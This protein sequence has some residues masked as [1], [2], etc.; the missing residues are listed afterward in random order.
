[1]GITK[2]L[3][4]QVDKALKSIGDLGT[5]VTITKKRDT[6]YDLE[7]SIV[8]DGPVGDEI[9]AIG[10]QEKIR[11]DIKDNATALRTSVL[12]DSNTIGRLDAYD[13]VNLRGFIWDLDSYND[14]GFITTIEL[15]RR[16]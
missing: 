10:Y 13:E 4:R 3:Q 15:R 1:M 2:K 7:N 16:L 9:I 14:D 8:V 6:T 11:R 5:E 12:F